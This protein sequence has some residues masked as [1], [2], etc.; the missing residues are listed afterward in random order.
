[1]N[2]PAVLSRNSSDDEILWIAYRV[3]AQNS[4]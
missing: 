1:M 4:S 3:E 2:P